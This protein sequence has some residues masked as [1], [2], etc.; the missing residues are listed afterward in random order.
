MHNA[1]KQLPAATMKKVSSVVIFGDPDK[2]QPL[3]G[4]T[5][6]SVKTICHVGDAICAGQA[7]ILAPHLTYSADANQAAA[8]VMDKSGLGIQNDS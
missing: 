6:S 7:L 3:P 1:A 2:G 4:I 8:F 5:S